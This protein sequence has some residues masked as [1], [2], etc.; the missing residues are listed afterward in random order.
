[1][2]RE[3]IDICVEKR[4]PE[5]SDWT[6][7]NIHEALMDIV[8]QVSGRVFVGPELCKDPEYLDCATKFTLDLVK[9][10]T[11]IKK[12]RPWTRFFLAPRLPEVRSLRQREDKAARILR[13]LVQERLDAAK[14]NPDWERPDD[15]T[16]W[17]L[18]RSAGENISIDELAMGQLMLIFAAI[19]TTSLTATNILY[20]LASTPEYIGPLR[21]EI[22][23]VIAEHDGNITAKALQQMEKL[24]SYMKE[25]NRVYVP[26]ISKSSRCLSCTCTDN[27]SLIQSSRA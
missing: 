25:V 11:A 22:L 20:T 2:V 6:P 7:V 8:A 23:S 24:D 5:C 27:V 16:Q 15:M 4:L 9:S 3:E 13:P 17:M 21:E 10:V 26:V 14:N 18:D 12:L 19:H 1:M